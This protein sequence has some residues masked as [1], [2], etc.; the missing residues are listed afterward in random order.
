MPGG[1]GVAEASLIG[2]LELLGMVGLESTASASALLARLATLWWA[3][4]CGFVGF[5]IFKLTQPK[6]PPSD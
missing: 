3:V 1:L 2:A 5:G 4:V 6:G